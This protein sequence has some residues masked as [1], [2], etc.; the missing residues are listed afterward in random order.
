MQGRLDAVALQVEEKT[1]DMLK[2]HRALRIA[3]VGAGIGGLT[4]AAALR[5]QGGFEVTVY[6]RAA[7]LGEV[8]A[9]LQVAP[10]A[11]N[12]RFGCR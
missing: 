6:E 9:G 8:G 5:Q 12:P 2:P 11:M 10:N 3:I 7:Q 1:L 4:A